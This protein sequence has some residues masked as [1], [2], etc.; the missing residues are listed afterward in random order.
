MLPYDQL[1]KSCPSQQVGAVFA[2]LFQFDVADISA[3]HIPS[4]REC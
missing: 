4:Y 1:C 2:L 3:C